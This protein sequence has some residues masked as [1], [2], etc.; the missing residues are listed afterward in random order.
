M[1]KH[2]LAALREKLKVAEI[3]FKTRLFQPIHMREIVAEMLDEFPDMPD[4]ERERV[5]NLQLAGSHTRGRV[6]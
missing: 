6:L 3:G 4:E 5:E 2:R 1:D